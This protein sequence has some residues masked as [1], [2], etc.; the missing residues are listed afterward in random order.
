MKSAVSESAAIKDRVVGAYGLAQ[1]PRAAVDGWM[2]PEALL[3]GG[4]RGTGSDGGR[5]DPNPQGRG[6][7]AW[8]RIKLS[9]PRRP[10]LKEK[11]A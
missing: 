5:P 6:I 2:A 11:R 9:L 8:L 7:R 4:W 10:G 1:A 3:A